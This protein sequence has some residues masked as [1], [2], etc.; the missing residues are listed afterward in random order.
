MFGLNKKILKKLAAK[1]KIVV[2][3]HH[4]KRQS[5]VS[6]F[7]YYFLY[8]AFIFFIEFNNMIIMVQQLFKN[9]PNS[10]PI[11][12]SLLHTLRSNKLKWKMWRGYF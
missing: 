5:Y 11:C 12:L 3:L 4:S 7:E 10:S 6:A 1:L 9:Y 2:T 8:R